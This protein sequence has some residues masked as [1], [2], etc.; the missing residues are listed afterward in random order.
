MKPIL[1]VPIAGKGQ[2]FVDDGFHMPKP[3]I[4]VDDKHIIDW[5]FLSINKDEYDIVFV[6]R[7]EHIYNF[8]MDTILRNKFSSN[9]I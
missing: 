4:M 6:V 2:R 9:N 1:L 3:L 5:S 8:G 7:K